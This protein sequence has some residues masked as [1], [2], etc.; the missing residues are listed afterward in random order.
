LKIDRTNL[1]RAVIGVFAVMSNR[2]LKYGL[3]VV[4]P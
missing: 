1:S 3:G 4:L 2:S